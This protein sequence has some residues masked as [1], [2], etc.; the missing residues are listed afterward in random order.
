MIYQSKQY[1]QFQAEHDKAEI[2]TAGGMPL[3]LKDGRAYTPNNS[4]GGPI[5]SGFT[6]DQFIYD[7]K[8]VGATNYLIRHSPWTTVNKKFPNDKVEFSRHTVARDLLKIIKFGHGTISSVKKNIK[9]G[10]ECFI[11]NGKDIQ[12]KD[13]IRF[14]SL[15]TITMQRKNSEEC[16]RYDL[17]Y[18]INMFN[19]LKDN[20]DLFVVTN[21]EGSWMAA[22]TFIYDENTVHYQFSGCNLAYSEFYPMERLIYEACHHYRQKG[23]E[24][25]HLG[26]GLCENDSLYKFKSKFGNLILEY[27]VSRGIV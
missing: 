1:M 5:I 19:L 3:L 15:Y 26:G 23:K 14:H 4:Y 24:L 27:Y 13:I 25:L 9:F 18:F 21:K 17:E 8:D 7:L 20:I 6:F 16:Y 2:I 11:I 10:C 22:A 12:S